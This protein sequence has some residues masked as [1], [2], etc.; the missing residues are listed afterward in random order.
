MLLK[1][2]LVAQVQDAGV[3][4]TRPASDKAVETA[5]QCHGNAAWERRLIWRRCVTEDRPVLSSFSSLF[6]F[7]PAY[8]DNRENTSCLHLVQIHL[9]NATTAPA[10]A[11][12]KREISEKK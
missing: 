9:H 4:R 10:Q 8:S 12:L 1:L 7:L 11:Q 3:S 2:P 6:F 5:A